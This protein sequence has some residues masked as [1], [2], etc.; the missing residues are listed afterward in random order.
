M[1]LPALCHKVPHVCRPCGSRSLR[2]ERHNRNGFCASASR[3]SMRFS[4]SYASLTVAIALVVLTALAALDATLQRGC[5]GT[6]SVRTL[7]AAST[8]R[9]RHLPHAP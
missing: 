3:R 8:P 6:M 4:N 1:D 2:L 9:R 7:P 5:I